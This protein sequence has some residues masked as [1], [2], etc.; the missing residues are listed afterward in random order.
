M[1]KNKKFIRDCARFIKGEI[2]E[3]KITGPTND[4]NILA[5]VVIESKKLYD[6][7]RSKEPD[8]SIVIV[9][10]RRKRRATNQLRNKMGLIWPL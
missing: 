7:L 1:K 9:G 5:S 8:M 6:T 4:V 2:S 10:L 3:I